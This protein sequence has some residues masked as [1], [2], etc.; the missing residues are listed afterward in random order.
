MNGLGYLATCNCPDTTYRGGLQPPTQA[1]IETRWKGACGL[2]TNFSF[3]GFGKPVTCGLHEGLFVN[4]YET[5]VSVGTGDPGPGFYCKHA[6]AV[7]RDALLLREGWFVVGFCRPEV[8]VDVL[9]RRV[10]IDGWLDAVY[11]K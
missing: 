5:I 4:D 2:R 6:L 11:V 8:K 3:V 10:S 9:F 1:Q 7:L